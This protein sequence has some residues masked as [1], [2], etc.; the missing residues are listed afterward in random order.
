MSKLNASEQA[1]ALYEKRLVAQAKTMWASA[2]EAYASKKIDFLTLI[3][4][5]RTS[6][7]LSMAYYETC[8][9][10]GKS[11]AQLERLVGVDLE[12]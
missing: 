1:I 2:R 11:F 5:A 3:D 12:E 10:F 7:E 4:A 6:K 8:A 9:N